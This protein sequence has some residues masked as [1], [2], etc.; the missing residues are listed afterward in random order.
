MSAFYAQR[1]P[2]R[3]TLAVFLLG[4]ALGGFFDGILVHQ[5]LQWHHLLSGWEQ[6]AF[7]DLSVQILADGL[8]HVLMYLLAI[9]GLVMLW[10]ARSDLNRC[11]GRKLLAHALMGFGTW[12]VLDSIVSH[13]ILGIHRVRM[14]AENPLMWD[15][16]WFVVFGLAFLF[17]G[18]LLYRGRG[19]DGGSSKPVVGTLVLAVSVMAPWAA[20]PP[21]QPS[22]VL[23]FFDQNVPGTEVF[24][25]ADAAQASIVWASALGNVWA[26]DVPDEGRRRRLLD[27][28]ATWVVSSPVL[29]G[30][31]AWT[32]S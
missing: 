29:I 26:M 8:F 6:G 9:L 12:H 16:L 21:Q 30:C 31:L 24:K 11:C 10:K 18:F 7:A 32:K 4:L 1:V 22:V 17:I 14:D 5:I 3:V 13:W 20:L 2:H 28:G 19:N 25:A 27:Y 23:V 15:L